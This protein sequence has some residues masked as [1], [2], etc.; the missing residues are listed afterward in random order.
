MPFYKLWLLYIYSMNFHLFHCC[1]NPQTKLKGLLKNSPIR[2]RPLTSLLC[3]DF[4]QYPLLSFCGTIT[5]SEKCNCLKRQT[6]AAWSIFE[7]PGKRVK[8]HRV[9][10]QSV[11]TGRGWLRAAARALIKKL[12]QCKSPQFL[13]TRARF[14]F[15]SE[16]RIIASVLSPHRATL[17][18]NYNIVSLSCLHRFALCDV[19]TQLPAQRSHWIICTRLANCEFYSPRANIC[20]FTLAPPPPPPTPTPQRWAANYKHSKVKQVCAQQM[21]LLFYYY[22]TGR[23]WASWSWCRSLHTR[24]TR[25]WIANEILN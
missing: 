23:E 21:R 12:K 6:W 19:I 14:S 8:G 16:I 10:N 1:T 22:F 25:M 11:H 5:R 13:S 3:C 7:K 4:E 2:H 24:F 18:S 20:M 15:C 17:N 9:S